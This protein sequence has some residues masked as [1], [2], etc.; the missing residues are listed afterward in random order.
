[1]ARLH[2]KN[3]ENNHRLE[4]GYYS[5]IKGKG[6]A[7]IDRLVENLILGYSQKSSEYIRYANEAPFAYR[8]RQLSSQLL[9][10]IDNYADAVQAEMPISRRYDLRKKYSK[11][12]HHGYVDFWLIKNNRQ[13]IIELKHSKENYLAKSCTKTTKDRFRTGFDQIETGA[14][15]CRDLK[16][17]YGAHKGTIPILLHVVTL[18]G[19]EKDFLNA[20]LKLKDFDIKERAKT[21]FD[22]I[23]DHDM[24]DIVGYW[25]LSKKS[26]QQAAWKNHKKLTVFYPGILF[27][28]KVGKLIQ[29]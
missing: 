16:G 21:L 13:F 14:R 9:P 4:I 18:W 8:E 1:M 23:S 11:E 28:F 24:I 25:S 5:R 27:A 20:K 26:F 17:Y 29:Q 12:E 3:I 7:D 19:S 15:F 2:F 22:T 10:A 6:K